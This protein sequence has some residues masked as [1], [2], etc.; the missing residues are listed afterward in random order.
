MPV[1]Y[2]DVS[3]EEEKLILATLDPLAALATRDNEKLNTLVN[4]VETELPGLDIDLSAILHNERTRTK[5][6]TH[7]VHECLCCKTACAPGCGCYKE[8]ATEVPQD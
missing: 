6:L 8:P 7:T 3:P 4:D 2:I 5:G 1:T